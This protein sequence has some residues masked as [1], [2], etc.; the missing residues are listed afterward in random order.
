[1]R[2]VKAEERTL[3]QEQTLAM[4][5]SHSEGFLLHFSFVFFAHS[6][7]HL[8]PSERHPAHTMDDK[9][10]QNKM[11]SE[12]VSLPHPRLFHPDVMIIL[13]VGPDEQRMAVHGQLLSQDSRFFQ[14]ALKEEQLEDQGKNRVIRLPEESPIH[15]GYYVEHMHGLPPPTHAL[16]EKS[17]YRV[18]EITEHYKLLAELYVVGE[19]RMDAKYQNQ[20]IQEL[21]RL[22]QLTGKSPG[23]DYANIIYQGTTAESPAR[24][25]AVD[26]AARCVGDYWYRDIDDKVPHAEFWCDL[27]KVLLQRVAK[28]SL[29]SEIRG[30]SLEAKDY[31]VG[32]DAKL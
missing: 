23:T 12:A 22:V 10:P 14:A 32:E 24:R 9:P 15:M 13:L 26:Y 20:I 3:R 21:F 25:V 6:A 11:S 16:G 5:P 30:A 4:F 2:K 19:R 29:A 28:H 27:S 31:L 7:H 1:M 18:P 8:L 17:H